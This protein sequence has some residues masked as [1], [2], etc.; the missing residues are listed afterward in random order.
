MKVQNSPA[1]C[2]KIEFGPGS[3]YAQVLLTKKIRA[4]IRVLPKGTIVRFAEFDSECGR[5]GMISSNSNGKIFCETCHDKS[6]TSITNVLYVLQNGL[7]RIK[8]G[9]DRHGW[10]KDCPIQEMGTVRDAN[11]T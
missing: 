7:N 6:D 3:E 4:K 11:L 5:I 1:F 9:M 2:G 10:A 8:R